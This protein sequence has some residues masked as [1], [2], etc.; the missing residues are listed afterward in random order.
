MQSRDPAELLPLTP[1]SHAI[2]LALADEDLHGYAIVQDVVTQSGGS[3]KPGTGTLY[4][5]LQRMHADG[6]I[7]DSDVGPGP[8][9]DQRRKYY[10]ITDFGR[11]TARA[12]ARR[13]MRVLDVAAEKSLAPDAG[14]GVE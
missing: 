7:A 10:A 13:L 2:L 8:D 12:E 9:E 11:E 1:L 6:L 4:A 3:I 5:A 14:A